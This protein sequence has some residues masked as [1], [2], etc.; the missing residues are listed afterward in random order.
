MTPR[1]GRTR[2]SLTPAARARFE[3]YAAYLAEHE[4]GLTLRLDKLAGLATMVGELSV[5][6]G[7]GVRRPYSI[8]LR[9][10]GLNPFRPPEVWDR[11]GHLAPDSERHVEDHG[12][13]G[14]R[15]CLWLPE[16]P[17][18]DFTDPGPLAPF[19]EKVR[20]FIFKQLIYQDRVRAGIPKDKAWPGPAWLHGHEGHVQWIQEQ[21][22]PL[23]PAEFRRLLPYL[24]G[25]RLSYNKRC[26]C[27][28]GKKSGLCHRDAAERIREALDVQDLR[29]AV[30]DLGYRRGDITKPVDHAD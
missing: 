12:R 5:N 20:G 22:G 24:L 23:S 14:W 13:R 9:F 2:P 17:E 8:E 21:L 16:A 6:V 15:W 25:N 11:G 18:V 4:P 19:L 30:E 3:S 26:P 28:S 1:V 7:A 27:G 10:E 29:K